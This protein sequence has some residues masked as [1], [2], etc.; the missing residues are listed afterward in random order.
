MIL[1]VNDSNEG[2]NS[3]DNSFS[4]SFPTHGKRLMI[5]FDCETTGGSHYSDHIIEVAAT[6]IV[7]DNTS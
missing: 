3:D 4:N 6:V 1:T 7:P 5:L 2:N